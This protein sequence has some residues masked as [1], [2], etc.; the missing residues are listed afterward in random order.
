MKLSTSQVAEAVGISRVAIDKKISRGEIGTRHKPEPGLPREWSFDEVFR[1]A[2]AVAITSSRD[3]SSFS[4]SFANV[5]IDNYSADMSGQFLVAYEIDRDRWVKQTDD[6]GVDICSG[7][8]TCKIVA[9]PELTKF[10]KGSTGAIVIDLE[11]VI[12]PVRAKLA[13]MLSTGR[14]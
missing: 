2:V 9:E 4:Q 8:W 6:D 1:L 3:G 12:T 14:L 10:L 7:I 11:A 5:A 13:T